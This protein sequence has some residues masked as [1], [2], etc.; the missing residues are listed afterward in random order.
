MCSTPGQE[1]PETAIALGC[2]VVVSFATF[3]VSF[4][5]TDPSS[6]FEGSSVLFGTVDT[7]GPVRYHPMFLNQTIRCFPGKFWSG[8]LSLLGKA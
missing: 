7:L 8:W 4:P 2:L 5:P 3:S 1:F 6:E